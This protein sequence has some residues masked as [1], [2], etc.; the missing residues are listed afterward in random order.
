M[1]VMKGLMV[2]LVAVATAAGVSA[3]TDTRH[4]VDNG[5]ASVSDRVGGGVNTA[6]VKTALVADKEIDSSA[7]NVDTV[8]ETK[9]V[10]LRGSVPTEAMKERAEMIAKRESPG[11]K[12]TNDL[13]V[14]SR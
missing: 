6:D 14:A 3:C 11:Y 12:V 2:G 4:D 7:I 10:V 13:M 1:N 5:T 8:A 9:T